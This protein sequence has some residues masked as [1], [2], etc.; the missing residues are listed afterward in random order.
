MSTLVY[1]QL[2]TKRDEA[3][4]STSTS[5]APPGVKTYIDAF[6]ALV[7]AEVLTLHALI[8]SATTKIEGDTTVI[9][10]RETLA[11]AFLGLLIVSIAL[12]VV[13]RLLA[14]KWDTLDWIRVAIPPLALVGWTMLQRTTAFD[15]VCP[16]MSE[17]ARTVSA[18]FLGVVLATVASALAYKADQK[19]PEKPAPQT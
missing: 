16:E 6:A 8:L 11:W 2:T 19:K 18:L 13:P 15:A 3:E 7:P 1:A 14:K 9:T 5:E 10:A 17:A 4:P 12:Y